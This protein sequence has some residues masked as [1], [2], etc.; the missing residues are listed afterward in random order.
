MLVVVV[1]AAA[2]A[3]G[4]LIDLVAGVSPPGRM[5]AFSFVAAIA[6]SLGAKTWGRH[7]VGRPAGTRPGELGRR[8]RPERTDG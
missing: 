3:V 7:V 8:A 6:L 2:L 4:V 5:A 1:V